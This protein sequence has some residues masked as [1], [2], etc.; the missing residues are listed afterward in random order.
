MAESL[1]S[2]VC[3]ICQENK[4]IICCAVNKEV[5]CPKEYDRGIFRKECIGLK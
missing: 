3:K 2:G 5:L 4:G 1:I